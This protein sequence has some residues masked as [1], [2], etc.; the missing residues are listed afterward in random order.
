MKGLRDRE[1]LAGWAPDG[2]SFFAYNTGEAPWKVVLVDGRTG[3]RT[4]VRDIVPAERA[5]RLLVAYVYVTPDGKA[6][7]YT[8]CRWQ[9][10]LHL[11]EGLK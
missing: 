10:E 5:G 4:T 9:S 8:T 2:Q 6:Y 3:A 7:A 11:I 1:A